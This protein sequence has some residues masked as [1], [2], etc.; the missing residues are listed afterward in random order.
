M[1]DKMLATGLMMIFTYMAL[2]EA[3]PIASSCV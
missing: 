3:G 2:I 1:C